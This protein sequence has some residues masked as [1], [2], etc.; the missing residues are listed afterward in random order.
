MF[1]ASKSWTIFW[2]SH[3]FTL[4]QAWSVQ[5]MLSGPRLLPQVCISVSYITGEQVDCVCQPV[6]VWDQLL[7]EDLQWAVILATIFMFVLL[8]SKDIHVDNNWYLVDFFYK[9]ENSKWTPYKV[10]KHEQYT[11]CCGCITVLFCIILFCLQYFEVF[12]GQNLCNQLC[13]LHTMYVFL[14]CQASN[15]SAYIQDDCYIKN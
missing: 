15:Y 14:S 4:S 2:G 12:C 13:S 11:T 1:F 6:S 8:T 5:M 7:L 10:K 3:L 9:A